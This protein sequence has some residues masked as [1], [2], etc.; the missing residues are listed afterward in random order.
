MIRS[1]LPLFV[2]IVLLASAGLV[3]TNASPPY[4]E[5]SLDEKKIYLGLANGEVSLFDRNA[6][7]ASRLAALLLRQGL[8][9]A[10]LNWEI[11]VPSDAD[12]VILMAP[13]EDYSGAQVARLWTYLSRG[14]NLLVL[15][16]PGQGLNLNSALMELMWDTFGIQMKPGFLINSL[17][18]D[19]EVIIS[20]NDIVTS[21]V[22][23]RD[24]EHPMLNTIETGRL[25]LES[26]CGLQTESVILNVKVSPLLTTA[27][28]YYGELNRLELQNNRLN[29]DIGDD[30][31]AGPQTVLAASVNNELNGARLAIL[32][33]GDIMVNEVGFQTSPPG[34]ESF[35]Y[36]ENV[37]LIFNA[38]YWVLEVE[39]VPELRFPAPAATST[40]TT[41]PSPTPTLTP[42]PQ[43]FG[44]G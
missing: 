9:L 3:A 24:V 23:V 42:T 1:I 6:G 7:G 5:R 25:V 29:F 40:P 21:L 28:Q 39:E 41:T 38:I 32:C 36:P 12:A 30:V 37:R 19:P 22:P 27:D 35:V 14:G 11:P 20:P 31:A 16:E 26:A 4:Q 8:E 44:D 2:V 17:Y 33:D 18:L 15:V 10:V 13:R 34:S 43:G